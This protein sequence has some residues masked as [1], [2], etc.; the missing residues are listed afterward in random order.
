MTRRFV[1]TNRKHDRDGFVPQCMSGE[2]VAAL[3]KG[4][5]A[6][7]ERIATLEREVVALKRGMR[8]ALD[9]LMPLSMG[10]EG[11]HLRGRVCTASNA[12]NGAL[13]RSQSSHGEKY[14]AQDT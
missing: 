9:E 10:V 8:A 14:E 1:R 12:L 11:Y 13:G 6:M 7:A 5:E 2:S 4:R 3:A